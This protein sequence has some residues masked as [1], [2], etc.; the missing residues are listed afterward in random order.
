VNKVIEKIKKILL[1]P[2][3]NEEFMKW[4]EEYHRKFKK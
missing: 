3:N 1:W 2:S 4:H